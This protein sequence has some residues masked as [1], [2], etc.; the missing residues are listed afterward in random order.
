ME[1]K[2]I[3]TINGPAVLAEDEVVFF[4]QFG[5]LQ[6]YVDADPE[7]FA[8]TFAFLLE[9]LKEQ[10]ENAIKSL[11]QDVVGY[12]SL[13]QFNLTFNSYQNLKKFE[14]DILNGHIH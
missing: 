6:D 4:H 13:N 10:S 7:F 12:D 3:N 9:S 11:S 5:P 14:F 8:K 2:L 1:Y